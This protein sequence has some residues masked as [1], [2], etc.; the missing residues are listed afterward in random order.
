M[1]AIAHFHATHRFWES[2]SKTDRSNGNWIGLP[3]DFSRMPGTK[4][5][6]FPVRTLL[7]RLY[8]QIDWF[9]NAVVSREKWMS[10]SVT[11]YA[12]GGWGVA[13]SSSI[14]G[15]PSSTG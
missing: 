2:C 4:S 7:I 10:Y 12:S 1:H 8:E 13:R 3:A 6:R 15:M 5:T 9:S 14:T 11:P